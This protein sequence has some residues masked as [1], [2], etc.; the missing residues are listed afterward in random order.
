MYL[1][2]HFTIEKSPK[3][4]I[5]WI[6]YNGEHISDSQ[7]CIDYLIKKF[8]KD[9]SEHLTPEEKSLARAFLKLT[10]ESIRW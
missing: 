7:F 10:E 9:L 4:K 3:G 5:P 8:D 2:N 6:T 1:K